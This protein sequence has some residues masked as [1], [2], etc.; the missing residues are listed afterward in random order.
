MKIGEKVLIS[1]LHSMKFGGRWGV[2]KEIKDDGLP[3][4]ITFGESILYGFYS[5]EIISEKTHL[6]ALLNAKFVQSKNNKRMRIQ[7]ASDKLNIKT[8]SGSYSL[9]DLIP[10]SYCKN[11]GLDTSGTF[12]EVCEDCSYPK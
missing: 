2:I 8:D 4:K 9:H 10:F 6:D 12:Q 3:F 1:P 5:S 11:C 7:D